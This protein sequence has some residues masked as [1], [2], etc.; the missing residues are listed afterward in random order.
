MIKYNDTKIYKWFTIVTFSVGVILGA[1]SYYSILH[2]EPTIKKLLDEGSNIQITEK[3][4]DAEKI[5]A[6]A[7]MSVYMT[8]A[9]KRLRNPQLFAR[10][11]N[12]D[13]FSDRIRSKFLPRFDQMV[14]EKAVITKEYRPYLEILLERRAQ[15]SRLGRNTMVFFFLLSLAGALFLLWERRSVKKAS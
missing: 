1:I 4:T 14:S 8:E 11:E 5:E 15:G 2:V 3:M 12:F 9:Y 7:K 6:R 10:Y 13:F